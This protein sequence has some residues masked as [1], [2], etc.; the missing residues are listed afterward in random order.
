MYGTC[1]HRC[2]VV[3]VRTSIRIELDGLQK[4][5]GGAC[6]GGLTAAAA[7]WAESKDVVEFFMGGGG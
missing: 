7:G 6:A 5:T 4:R 2:R 3:P 1:M